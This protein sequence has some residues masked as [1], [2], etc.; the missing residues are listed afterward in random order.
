MARVAADRA[1]P[2]GLIHEDLL[3]LATAARN[4][5]RSTLRA[6]QP[7]LRSHAHVS[8]QPV[9]PALGLGLA[10]SRFVHRIQRDAT[11]GSLSLEPVPPKPM[12]GG[13]VSDSQTLSNLL[14]GQALE[15]ERLELVAR[16]TAF[17]G[18]SR[19]SICCQAMLPQPVAHRR[20]MLAR[21]LADRFKRHPFCQA[22]LQKPLVHGEILT[23][24][25]DRT[26]RGISPRRA[27][28]CGRCV[29]PGR[30]APC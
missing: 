22:I 25:S 5:L 9:L 4:R 14:D 29:R 12:A 20:G 16:D 15:N 24:A 19:R 7:T 18:V 8:N 2:A 1:L 10:L 13:G 28:P 23:F 26:F 3:D 21:Q 11:L 27:A 30:L 6:S 17:G